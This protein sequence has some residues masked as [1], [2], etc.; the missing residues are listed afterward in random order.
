MSEDLIPFAKCGGIVKH[1]I[2]GNN[3]YYV[4]FLSTPITLLL[5]YTQIMFPSLKDFIDSIGE[6]MNFF[7]E[8]PMDPRYVV[9]TSLNFSKP[10]FLF[11]HSDVA[12]PPYFY[13]ADCSRK[14]VGD[15]Q[16]FRGTG[17]TYFDL[18][19]DNDNMR[20]QYVSELQCANKQMLEAID[21]IIDKDK[22]AIII[23]QSDHGWHTQNQSENDPSRWSKSHFL[24][25][26]SILNV[27]RLPSHCNDVLYPS[28]SPVNTF[29]VVFSC[30]GFRRFDLLPDRSFFHRSTNKEGYV[31]KD[32]NDIHPTFYEQ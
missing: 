21:K 9:D 20:A 26:F 24:E 1:C 6:S 23:I 13:N 10:Y 16:I 29:R 4:F 15:I 14:D 30:I 17:A 28:I 31:I 5:K 27:L 8:G 25:S 12:H 2:I 32:I 19:P 11:A 22:D 18:F 3:F 7:R